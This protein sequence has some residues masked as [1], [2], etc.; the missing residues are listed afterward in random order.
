MNRAY[1]IFTVKSVDEEQRVIE[2][3]ATTPTT[4]RVGDIVEPRGAKF[5]LPL[6]LLWQHR[7]SEPVGHVTR[8][9]VSDDGITI[10]ARF[11]RVS[12]PG[13][14]QDRLDEAWQSIKHGLVRGLSIGFM[15][16]EDGMEPINP[17]KPWDGQRITAWDWLE[18]SA[19]TIPANAEASIQTIKSIDQQSR[20]AALR[21]TKATPVRLEKPTPGA[22]GSTATLKDMAMKTIKEQISAFEAKRAAS[23][24]AATEI[25]EKAG[26]K[27]ETLS[28]ED[29]Q[30]YD[31]LSAEVKEVDEHLERLRET[32]ALNVA[33][34]VAVDASAGTDP[35]L[36]SK[37]RAPA[38]SGIRVESKLEPGVRFARMGMALARAKGIM[39]LAEQQYRADKRWMD[40]APEVAL[41]LKAAVNAGDSTTSGWASEWAYAENIGSEFIEFLRPQ[42]LIG[43]I[44]GWRNVPFNVRVGSTTGGSTGYWVGQ[45][46][47]IPMSKLTSSSVSLGIAKVAG[48]VGIDKELARLSTPSAELMVRNDLARECQ[49]V[50]DLSL[51]DPN[52]GGQTNIQPA[53][54]IYGVTPITPTG[55]TYATFVADWKNLVSTMINANLGLSG[56]VVLMSETTAIAL[57]LMVTS[58]G[59]PQFPG[60]SLAGGT[61]NG[62]P[63]IVS[64]Q[65]TIAGS[66]QYANIIVL[67]KP[68][69]VFLADDGQ[70]TVEASDQVS[71]EMLDNPTNQ[72]T[73]T[74][75]ATTT[76][77]MWQTESIAVK[78]VR[79][80]NW[81]KARSQAAA[82]ITAAAYTG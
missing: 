57:S 67:L 41:A 74:S 55:V 49:K 64:N 6:P 81:A 8:A 38:G 43:R 22:T 42:T 51:I 56:C 3:V 45:G 4:D 35:A 72:S 36:A 18:L 34:A 29:K 73:A 24:A 65:L 69:E 62:L 54:L 1:S 5:K 46:K 37:A 12:E 23:A 14:L 9:S 63:V 76:V 27:G 39:P 59:N 28:A 80:I 75:T 2:G 79:Y 21:A 7:S 50:L 13:R 68:G 19:V 33:K 15:P 31:A 48:M 47:P 25:M 32:E 70:A 44:T 20:S 77:S 66:P 16:M 60:L 53:S 40:S 10:Q 11:A 58:L 71:I 30:K 52:Q 78:A 26:E 82:W 61:L 17:K